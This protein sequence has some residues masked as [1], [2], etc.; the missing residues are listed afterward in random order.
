VTQGTEN[1]EPRVGDGQLTGEAAEQPVLEV[2][3]IDT[4]VAEERSAE[5]LVV[6]EPVV[7]ALVVVE[8]ETSAG[9][10]EGDEVDD[11]EAAIA[12]ANANLESEPSFDD[13]APG[14]LAGGAA[15]AD[16]PAPQS[17]AGASVSIWPFVVYDALW[18][19]FAGTLIWRF[20][21]LP[22]SEAVFESPLYII[23]VACG[24]ALT[25]AGPALILATWLASWGAAGVSKGAL[26]VSAL[27]KGAVATTAG[28]AMW[29]IALL[30]LDQLRLGR[31]L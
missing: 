5:A 14:T 21:Q 19:V 10:A 23:A 13:I 11:L 8:P 15:W 2:P 7:D 28:V 29:W 27:I 6:V 26:F 30:V 20:Q 18:L 12:E 31:L 1:D 22:A 4:P 16:E 17:V 3:E 9:V 25:V 24:V